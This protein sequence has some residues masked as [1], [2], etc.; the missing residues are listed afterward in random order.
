MSSTLFLEFISKPWKS[1]LFNVGLRLG[2]LLTIL[3]FRQVH[4][5]YFNFVTLILLWKRF[6]LHKLIEP[7]KYGTNGREKS[8][9]KLLLVLENFEFSMR[10]LIGSLSIRL[11]LQLKTSQGI[12]TCRSRQLYLINV[13]SNPE[14][15]KEQ[16]KV[17]TNS[18]SDR[19]AF[20]SSVNNVSL[21]WRIIQYNNFN[22][23]H[24]FT[25]YYFPLLTPYALQKYL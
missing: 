18:D 11:I 14:I 5:G 22:T 10:Y 24:L 3:R 16:F 4:P 23:L 15:S 9:R 19:N 7:G 13:I 17:Q 21:V 8:N 1:S 25:L 6:H 12:H 20:W 2:M